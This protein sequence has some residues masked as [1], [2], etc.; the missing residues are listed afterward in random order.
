MKK[1]KEF[2]RQKLPRNSQLFRLFQQIKFS[3]LGSFKIGCSDNNIHA[4]LHELGRIHK[5]N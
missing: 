4:F 1:K 5:A 3:Y 2:L